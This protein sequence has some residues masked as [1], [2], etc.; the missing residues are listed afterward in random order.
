MSADSTALL[1]SLSSAEAPV[2]WNRRPGMS[3]A[4]AR[5]SSIDSATCSDLPGAS[6]TTVNAVAPSRVTCWGAG[7]PSTKAGSAVPASGISDA[8]S[9]FSAI[10]RWSSGVRPPSRW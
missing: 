3:S 9:A 6:G 4:S 8:S 2:T 5:S 10:S 1:M 7:L